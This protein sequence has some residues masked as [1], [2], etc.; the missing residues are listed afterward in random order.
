MDH[1]W[2]GHM[3]RS[4]L[5][6]ASGLAF[7]GISAFGNPITSLTGRYPVL[8]Q[9]AHNA[10]GFIE[11]VSDATSVG[12][13]AE[14]LA[15]VS[16]PIMDKRLLTAPNVTQIVENGGLISQTFQSAAGSVL[17][18]YLSGDGY[19]QII[20]KTCDS[21][22]VCE[23][24]SFDVSTGKSPGN[25]VD[26][27]SFFNQRAGNYKLIKTALTTPETGKDE[28]FV[29]VGDGYSLVSFQYCLPNFCDPIYLYWDT[30]T[31]AVYERV[32]GDVTT[33]DI[34][35]EGVEGP[36][37]YRWEEFATGE[38]RFQNFHWVKDGQLLGMEHEIQK[39]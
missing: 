30:P 14:G 28:G 27:A 31:V 6:L 19:M 34:L 22:N 39:L 24:T 25:L 3:R 23:Q 7:L 37:Y 20:A 4:I 29:E 38:Q 1:N 17:I 9:N 12:I 18:T 13:K 16:N 10:A 8:T 33:Y 32:E 35:A 36:E 2:E 5:R 26:T 11:I 15:L 21:A